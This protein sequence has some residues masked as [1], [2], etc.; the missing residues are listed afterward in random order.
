MF[1]LLLSLSIVLL[2]SNCGS[3][4]SSRQAANGPVQSM[5]PR[6]GDGPHLGM[7]VGFD[8]L[9][10]DLYDQ[11]ARVTE[12]TSQAVAAG[13]NISR[14]QIDWSE[15]ESEIGYEDEVLNDF[16]NTIRS[17]RLPAYVTLS[18]LD[19]G[20]LTLPDYLMDMDGVGL[21]PDLTITS[22]EVIQAFERFLNWFIPSLTEVGVWGISLGN[23]GDSL[24]EDGDVNSQ[25]FIT[26]FQAGLARVNSIDPDM[27]S[28]VT[29]TGGGYSNFPRETKAILEHSDH[30][31]VNFYCL[32]IGFQ[33]TRE[34]IW[35][36]YLS[37]LKGNVGNKPIFFQELG[38]PAGYGDDGVGAPVR[39]PNG[40]SGSSTIQAEFVEYMGD[41]FI[42]DQQFIGATWF[43]LL[44]WSPQ[45]AEDFVSP[46]AMESPVAGALTEEWLATSGIC[47]WAD[48]TCRLAWD[49]WLMTLSDVRVERESR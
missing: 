9:T 44:D 1:K 2:I 4:S 5:I 10:T 12:L 36:A 30:A 41:V 22:P 35:E 19:S 3:N 23:E 15:L 16:L 37:D 32:D 20:G 38:C 24:L 42:S 26:F 6:L 40:L 28:S 27:S 45:L 7:I 47:R 18:T 14:F 34:P 43:Q 11:P 29:F 17:S 8:P 25:D 31:T 49:Q 21:R 13:M 48:G 46:I 39:P 33:V